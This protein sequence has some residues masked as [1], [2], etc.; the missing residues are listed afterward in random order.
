LLGSSRV[1]DHL[2]SLSNVSRDNNCV[3]YVYC[4]YQGQGEQSTLNLLGSLLKQA[5][6]AGCKLPVTEM[7][8]IRDLLD[9]KKLQQSL[10]LDEA[11]ETLTATLKNFRRTYICVDALDECTNACRRHF[12]T[13]LYQ[14]RSKL[15][16]DNHTV[17]L[18]F[19]GRPQIQEDTR[20]VSS[21]SETK[22]SLHMR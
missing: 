9:K 14:L 12:I 22:E 19:T 6:I 4:D 21:P 18:F 20:N 13:T 11:F 3:A 7:T 10:K 16:M 15:N 2:V 8:A 5:V 17:M 1:I